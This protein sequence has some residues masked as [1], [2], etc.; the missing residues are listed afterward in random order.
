[1]SSILRNRKWYQE[2]S[3]SSFYKETDLERAVILN[4]EI[5]FENFKAVNFK[6][7]LYDS[8]NDRIKQADLAMIKDDYK[9]WYVIEVELTH[10]PDD[11]VREQIE[12]FN[13]CD[14]NSK[15]AE[16]IYNQRKQVFDK[17]SLIN[18]VETIPAKFMVIANEKKD[19]WQL[20]LKSNN[21]ILSVFQIYLNKKNH[22]VY[23]INGDHPVV[24]TEFCI[25]KLL[26]K[27]PFTVKIL[28]SNLFEQFK[29][30]GDTIYIDYNGIYTSW[31][32]LRSKNDVYLVCKEAS[33]LD[34]STDRYMLSYSKKKNKYK[35]TK[36]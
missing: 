18:M 29:I 20:M 11:H 2:I 14:Y 10:H 32:I 17:E 15:H 3:A 8:I 27:I 6:M 35:F 36:A 12:S 33:P 21:C 16:Y 24:Y 34:P 22:V 26:K 31:S 9:E 13:N 30:K 4:L 19:K 5:V 23:R 7:D 28:E 1:M 25:C